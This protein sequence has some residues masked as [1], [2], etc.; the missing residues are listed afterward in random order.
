[1]EIVETD[2]S[3]K[4]HIWLKWMGLQRPTVEADSWVPVVRGLTDLDVDPANPGTSTVGT[5]LVK[6]LSDAGIEASQ[7]AYQFDESY[8]TNMYSGAKG[9]ME[10]R[11]A[12]LVHEHDHARAVAIAVELNETLERE[13]T[14]LITDEELTQAAL[15]EAEPPKD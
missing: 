12:V 2:S 15:D 7:R 10:T 11:V 1:M 8:V 3:P 5:R 14:K 9:E 6:L 13:E 4:Q